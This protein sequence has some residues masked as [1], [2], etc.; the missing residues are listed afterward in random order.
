MSSMKRELNYMTD[1]EKFLYGYKIQFRGRFT[2]RSRSESVSVGYGR[3]STSTITAVIDYATS[4]LT[5]RN[6]SGSVKVWL[7][8]APK[9]KTFSYKIL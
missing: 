1:T 5:L 8:R 9:F 7:Y 3:V 2:R 4:S 6:G